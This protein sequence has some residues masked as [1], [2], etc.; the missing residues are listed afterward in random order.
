MCVCVC[1]Y[2]HTTCMPAY[3][4][5]QLHTPICIPERQ[6]GTHFINAPVPEGSRRISL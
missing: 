2:T 1:V 3:I 4:Y 6:L 5:I